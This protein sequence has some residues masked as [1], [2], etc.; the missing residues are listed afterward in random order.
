MGTPTPFVYPVLPVAMSLFYL[1]KKLQRIPG[2]SLSVYSYCFMKSLE[3]AKDVVDT[4]DGLPSG[5]LTSVARSGKAVSAMKEGF[6][7]CSFLRMCPSEQ[8]I[9]C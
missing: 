2:L 1:L 8:L 3:C 7:Y 5:V 4:T 6:R 9:S